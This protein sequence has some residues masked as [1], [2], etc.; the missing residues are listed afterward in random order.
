MRTARPCCWPCS[1]VTPDM[2]EE[3]RSARTDMGQVADVDDVDVVVVGAGLGG[4]ATAAYLAVA[5][6]RVVVVDRHSVAGGNGTVFTHEGYEFDV[7]LHYVGDCEPGGLFDRALDPLDIH[8]TYRE[9]DR[10]GPDWCE[11][12]IETILDW[13]EGEA[14][15]RPLVGFLFSRYLA[16]K[17]VIEAISRA[18]AALTSAAGS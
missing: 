13:L 9:M 8:L 4:L 1:D 5:G 10:D 18:R 3:A 12:N 14:R 6:K 15:S 7:G 2:T 17:V 11:A 16:R